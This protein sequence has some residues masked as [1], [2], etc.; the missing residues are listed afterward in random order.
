VFYK[1]QWDKTIIK[2]NFSSFYLIDAKGFYSPTY[3]VAGV[4]TNY[5]EIFFETD[6]VFENEAWELTLEGLKPNGL[7]GKP[8]EYILE[9]T[10][11]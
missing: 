6:R 1:D 8:Q 2:N 9:K 11:K 7:N 3:K 4:S 5:F 10:L